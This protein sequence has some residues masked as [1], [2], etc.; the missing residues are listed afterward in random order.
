METKKS[1]A[2]KFFAFNPEKRSSIH[3]ALCEHALGK[4][5]LYAKKQNKIEYVETVAGTKQEV[6]KQ[7]PS[8]AFTSA[9]QGLDSLDV[10]QRYQEPMTALQDDDLTFPENITF[11]YYAIYNLFKKYVKKEMV[12]DWLIVN[13]VLSIEND[14]EAW[15]TL[16]NDAI[17]RVKS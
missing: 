2:D 5:N 14:S 12:D 16:L 6:D 8:D 10:A 7:L 11:A 3:F 13:Q 17:Q 15:E 1:L 9:M 4:W